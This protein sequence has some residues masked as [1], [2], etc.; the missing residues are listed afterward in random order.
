MST[1]VTGGTAHEAVSSETAFVLDT[2]EVRLLTEVG[3]LA[4][5][6]GDLARADAIFGALRLLRPDRA[7]PYI[8]LAT[9]RMNAGRAADAVTVLEAAHITD[10]AGAQI[11]R[12][13]YGLALQQAG[14]NDES[15]RVLESVVRSGTGDGV[16]L[17]RVLLG[18]KAEPA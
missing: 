1:R 7:F 14:R 2:D 17:A 15:R 5:G 11:V 8:G 18:L 6:C 16:E 12:T 9:A 3:F 13:W 4:A 10:T